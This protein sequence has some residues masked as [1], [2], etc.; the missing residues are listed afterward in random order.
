[1]RRRFGLV[2]LVA[3]LAMG[4]VTLAWSFPAKGGA[5]RIAQG[6]LGVDIRDLSDEQIAA[7]KL[8]D[9]RGAEVVRLDHDGPACKAGV[10]EHDVVIQ[11]DG[12]GIDGQDQFRRMLHETPAGRTVT[13]LIVRDGQQQTLKAT[14]ANREEVERMAWEQHIAVVDP[15]D[16]GPPPPVSEGPSGRVGGAGLGFLHGGSSSG[17]NR[18]FLGTM[19]GAP[20]TGAVVEPITPQLGE[21]FGVQSGV[22]LLVKSIEASSPAAVAGMRAGDVVLKANQATMSTES[23]WTRSLHE[24]R[25]RQIPI[26]VLRDRKEQTLSL[27]PDAKRKSKLERPGAPWNAP[28]EIMLARMDLLLGQD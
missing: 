18:S 3:T 28:D 8:T 6:Y 14:M 15:D 9:V 19:L 4:T 10:R 21:F 24:N 26:M 17:K 13:L 7:L 20:Y 5:G 12:H 23:D 16:V 1:M 22:G 2:V 27:T 11:M 25:G